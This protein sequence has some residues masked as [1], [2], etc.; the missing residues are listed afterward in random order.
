MVSTLFTTGER[1]C[2]T[3]ASRE[4]NPLCL[5]LFQ[6]D[7]EVR[8]ALGRVPSDF[9]SPDQPNPRITR[10]QPARKQT[11]KTGAFLRLAWTHVR[12]VVAIARQSSPDGFGGIAA[13]G[14]DY[15]PQHAEFVE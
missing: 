3:V 5:T 11:E 1:I 15:R 12:D 9:D 4:R 14:V 10:N 2:L 7:T 6:R 8:P 13:D